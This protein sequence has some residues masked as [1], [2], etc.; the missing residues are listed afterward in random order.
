MIALAPPRRPKERVPNIADGITTGASEGSGATDFT[1]QRQRG[2]MTPHRAAD[3]GRQM[4]LA[5]SPGY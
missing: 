3:S 1:V 4:P 5:A 2:V